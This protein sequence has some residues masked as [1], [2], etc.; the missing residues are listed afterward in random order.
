M[1]ETQNEV[2]LLELGSFSG[3]WWT[4]AQKTVWK[5]AESV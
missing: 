2:I 5:E 4:N 3:E 1:F